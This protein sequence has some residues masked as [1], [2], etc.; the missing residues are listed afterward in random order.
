M[1]FPLSSVMNNDKPHNTGKTLVRGTGNI[2]LVDDQDLVRKV[3]EK[4]LSQLGYNVAVAEDGV[5]GLAYYKQHWATLDV[6]IVDMIMPNMNGL[7]CLEE[8]KKVNPNLRA[9]LATGYSRD[10]ISHKLND[11]HI[12]GFMQKP[13]RLH[14]LSKLIAGATH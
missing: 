6:V 3:G 10:E 11:K 1:Y 14:E 5:Q 8:M 2:L 12:V 7:E 9:I 4:M 13:Y